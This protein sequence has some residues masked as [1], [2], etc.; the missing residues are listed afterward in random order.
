MGTHTVKR[1]VKDRN[2]YYKD[3]DKVKRSR[4]F[5]KSWQTDL[6]EKMNTTEMEESTDSCDTESTSSVETENKSLYESDESDGENVFDEFMD[7]EIE[8]S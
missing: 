6:K 1:K 7:I 5:R 4:Q 8:Q 3:Y 2:D